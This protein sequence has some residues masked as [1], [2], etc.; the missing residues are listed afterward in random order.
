MPNIHDTIAL[1]LHA[2]NDKLEDR[3]AVQKMV[4][5]YAQLSSDAE[6]PKYDH[7]FYGPF[8]QGVAEALDDMSEFSFIDEDV[9]SRYYETYTYKLT[10]KGKEYA[11]KAKKNNPE[12]YKLI[13]KIV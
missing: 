12:D 3:T 5:F 1:F 6:I 2:N 9:V 13:S 8:S 4:Y 7:H 11:E 10:E